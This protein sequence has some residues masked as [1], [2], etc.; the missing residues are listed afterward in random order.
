MSVYYYAYGSNMDNERI[1]RRIGQQ[2]RRAGAILNGW[3]L[4][5]NKQAYKNGLPV[6]GEGKGNIMPVRDKITEGILYE[7]SLD[8]LKRLAGWE[9]GYQPVK[10]KVN[11]KDGRIVT[12]TTFVAMEKYI[13]QSLK[14]TRDYLK[15]YWKGCRIISKEYCEMLH[16]VQ[17]LD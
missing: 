16:K 8:Q 15:H 10:V 13:G 6:P 17:T 2:T 12:A 5:F 4:A 9:I 3:A 11:L 7:V 1:S 14:P